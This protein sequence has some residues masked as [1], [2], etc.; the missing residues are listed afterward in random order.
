MVEEAGDLEA[1]AVKDGSVVTDFVLNVY[2][3]HYEY[4]KA[5]KFGACIF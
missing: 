3:Q 1:W 4:C 5:R 2:S